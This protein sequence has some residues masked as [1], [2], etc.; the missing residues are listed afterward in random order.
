M[1]LNSDAFAECTKDAECPDGTPELTGAEVDK[2]QCCSNML[3]MVDVL[4]SGVDS[5]LLDAMVCSLLVARCSFR[6]CSV[7]L[8]SLPML[9]TADDSVCY[10]AVLNRLYG[11]VTW[12]KN[13]RTQ[14]ASAAALRCA[15]LFSCP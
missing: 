4:C 13:A 11:R 10:H 3:P 9:L 2:L 6:V 7:A 15:P 12:P 8:T 5:K 14:I 1:K